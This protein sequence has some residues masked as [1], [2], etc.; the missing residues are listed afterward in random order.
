MLDG[1]RQIGLRLSGAAARFQ[2]RV[3]LAR[4]AGGDLP[5]VSDAALMDILEDWLL[6]WLDGVRTEADWRRFDILP[7]LRARLTHAQM[8]EIDR[9]LPGHFTTPLGRSVPIDYASDGPEI[10][11]RLQ[12]MLGVTTHPRAAGQPI[13][14]TLLSPGQKPIAVVS[15]LPGFWRSSYP[16]VRKEMRGRYPRHPWPESPWEAE[17]TLRAKPRGT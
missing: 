3:A 1:I 10:E 5:D 8:Q 15:D 6:P 11:V 12:E 14:I 9:L 16:E 17:P 7:A 4:S 2:A 13:R